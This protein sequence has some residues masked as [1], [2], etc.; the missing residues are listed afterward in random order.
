MQ[1][2][3]SDTFSFADSEEFHTCPENQKKGK[4]TAEEDSLLYKYAPLYNEK[5][6]HKIASFVPGRSSI[7]C[8]HRWTKILKPGLIK[9]MWTPDED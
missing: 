9:G 8:L 5:N 7:Q 3:F 1:Q 4:W 6:W 2:T